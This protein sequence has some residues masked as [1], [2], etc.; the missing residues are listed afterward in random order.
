MNTLG[1]PQPIETAPLDQVILTEVGMVCHVN[2][3]D[4]G[5]PVTNGWYLCDTDGDI[6]SCADD[7]MNVSRVYPKKWLPLPTFN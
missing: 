1:A 7:G 5:S 6:I 4:W 3:R 2:Q